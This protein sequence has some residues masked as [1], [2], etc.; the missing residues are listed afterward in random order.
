MTISYDPMMS[1]L[2]LDAYNR[3]YDARIELGTSAQLGTATINYEYQ[4]PAGSQA[5]SFFAQAYTLD[6]GETVIS[7]A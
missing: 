1:I 3:G 5:A 7:L 2:A 4:I 6:T